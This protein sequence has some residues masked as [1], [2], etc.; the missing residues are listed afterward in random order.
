MPDDA[1]V[2]DRDA[3]VRSRSGRPLG[4]IV[5]GVR[6]RLAAAIADVADMDDLR[7]PFRM[8]T[9]RWT[10]EETAGLVEF[11]SKTLAWTRRRYESTGD[12]MALGAE[13]GRVKG[14]L[15]ELADCLES[16]VYAL[17]QTGMSSP[18]PM[19]DGLP[20][21]LVDV[22]DR[23]LANGS[24]VAKIQ[25]PA[26]P[27]GFSPPVQDHLRYYVYLLQDPR[28]GS[29]FYVGKGHRNRV[30]DHE[31]A[32]LVDPSPTDKLDRIRSI[33]EAGLRPEALLLRFGL[34]ERTAFVV[35]GAAIQ[36]LGLSNL[37]N[38]VQGH[39]VG[40]GLIERGQR[41][42][43]VRSSRSSRHLGE[44]AHVQDPKALGSVDVGGGSLPGD[45]RLVE[46]GGPSQRRRLCVRGE[47]GDRA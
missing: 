36:L 13:E 38:R 29:V 43:H 12:V 34:D 47:S 9:T 30:F 31:Q 6:F 27:T 4:S 5:V 22:V 41:N 16:T 3:W 26:T 14:A 40:E 11:D 10:D 42:Q 46:G 44:G 1:L 19:P 25:F 32:A 20:R 17:W 39:H 45:T 24:L 35:E 37:T 33:R 2:C 21:Q 18:P 8:L 15:S 7:P 23:A 28:D